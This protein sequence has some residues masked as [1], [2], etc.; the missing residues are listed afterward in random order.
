MWNHFKTANENQKEKLS[1]QPI[2]TWFHFREPQKLYSCTDRQNA[3][4]VLFRPKGAAEF[5]S[6]IQD[7]NVSLPN[8]KTWTLHYECRRI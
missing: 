4:K 3:T 7:Q 5:N 1:Y 2:F 6:W 8:V